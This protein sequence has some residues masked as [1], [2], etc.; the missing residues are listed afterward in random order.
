MIHGDAALKT[1]PALR[2]IVS[3][4]PALRCHSCKEYRLSH[5]HAFEPCAI[6]LHQSHLEIRRIGFPSQSFHPPHRILV[7]VAVVVAGV[8]SLAAN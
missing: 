2:I 4:G 3:V 5:L 1:F 7:C 6:H 8:L